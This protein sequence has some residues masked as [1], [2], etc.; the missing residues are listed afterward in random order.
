MSTKKLS[1]IKYRWDSSASIDV[2]NVPWYIKWDNIQII[3][4]YDFILYLVEKYL[5]LSMCL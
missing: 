1:V 5:L 3:A 4:K 2:N